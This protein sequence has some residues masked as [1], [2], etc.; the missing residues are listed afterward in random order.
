MNRY[1]FHKLGLHFRYDYAIVFF[2]GLALVR[3]IFG[4]CTS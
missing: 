2:G 1:F 3:I 4:P